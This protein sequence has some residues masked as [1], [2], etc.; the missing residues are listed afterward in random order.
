MFVLVG[1]IQQTTNAL[2]HL[3]TL[4]MDRLEKVTGVAVGVLLTT[5]IH[6]CHR[7][8]FIDIRPSIS[9]GARTDQI[10]L[11]ALVSALGWKGKVKI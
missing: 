2:P 7:I 10:S 6:S 9:T 5:V 4:M 8:E 1:A 11:H 3:R